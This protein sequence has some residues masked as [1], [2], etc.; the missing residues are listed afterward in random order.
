M[1]AVVVMQVGKTA[2]GA[3]VAKL[4]GGALNGPTQG[5]RFHAKVE[6]VERVV[7]LSG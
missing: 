2:V 1:T 7:S 4:I 6:A 3:E 5:P